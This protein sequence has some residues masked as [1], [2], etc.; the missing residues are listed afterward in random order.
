MNA[1]TASVVRKMK[2]NEGRF[3]WQDSLQAGQP[4]RLLGHP[5]VIAED[6]PDVAADSLS[7]AFGNWRR[8]YTIVGRIG[9]RMLR[10]PYTDKYHVQ[11]FQHGACRRVHSRPPGGV[12]PRPLPPCGS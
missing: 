1:A 12:K 4:D 6:M 9:M 3:T 2:D 5:V 8:G 11:Y 7:V 10:D